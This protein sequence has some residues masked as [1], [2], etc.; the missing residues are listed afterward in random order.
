MKG[1][2]A[3]LALFGA[4]MQAQS[5][6]L[7]DTRQAATLLQ[8]EAPRVIALWSLDCAY[9]EANLRKLDALATERKVELVVVATDSPERRVEV[10]ARL[11]ALKL[12]H[13]STWIYAEDTPERLNYR[14]DP[15]WGGELPRTLLLP[16]GEAVSGALTEKQLAKWREKLTPRS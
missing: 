11:E 3:I 2:L 9:C 6:E 10:E 4:T 16:S 1:W 5:L 14:I 7:L 13:R 12:T 15:Q 8:G